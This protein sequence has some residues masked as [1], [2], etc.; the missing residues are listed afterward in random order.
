[1]NVFAETESDAPA[2]NY[3]VYFC[4]DVDGNLLYVGHTR[5]V[6]ERLYHHGKKSSWFGLC[7]SV[8]V[9]YFNTHQEAKRAEDKAIIERAPKHNRATNAHGS[10]MNLM[11]GPKAPK[12]KTVLKKAR[13]AMP[14]D[15]K[16]SP[17]PLSDEDKAAMRA[18]MK[19]YGIT[20]LADYL[21]FAGLQL[22]R[23]GGA[24]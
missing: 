3:A 11:F 12:A 18:G 19:R 1:M 5:S 23:T 22:A 7:A 17:V 16:R 21:R 13:V 9:A 20:T 15:T 10:F 8:G 14:K 2:K 6:K 4:Y 24:E